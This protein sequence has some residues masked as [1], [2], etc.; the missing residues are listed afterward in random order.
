M[1][2]YKKYKRGIIKPM[3]KKKWLQKQ[4]DDHIKLKEKYQVD[5]FQKDSFN[6]ELGKV[7]VL[8][9]IL[10]E[11]TKPPSRNTNE[12]VQ[13]KEFDHD[14]TFEKIVKFYIDKK[15]YSKEA[16]VKI[17]IIQI[18]NQKQEKLF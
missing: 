14:K 17:A 10:L 7:V 13:T 15:G 5:P 12:N 9:E 2:Q 16:A 3:F 11:F 8:R 4:I 18:H 6:Q 1:K